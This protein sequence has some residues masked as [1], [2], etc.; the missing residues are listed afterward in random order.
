MLAPQ[1]AHQ[2]MDLHATVAWR[3]P[4]HNDPTARFLAERAGADAL[5]VDS[6][7][8]SLVRAC[9]NNL[10]GV[11]VEDVRRHETDKRKAVEDHQLARASRPR[12]HCEEVPLR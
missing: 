2:E 1:I 6:R 9:L 4:T 8:Q 3:Q 10:I 5:I 12:F 7:F 11:A